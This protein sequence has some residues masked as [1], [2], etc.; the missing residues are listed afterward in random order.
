M[1]QIFPAWW[2]AGPQADGS[3]RSGDPQTLKSM[4]APV[5]AKSRR[6]TVRGHFERDGL[7]GRN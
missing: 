3:R 6:S 4:A 7:D 5:C 1:G 2:A